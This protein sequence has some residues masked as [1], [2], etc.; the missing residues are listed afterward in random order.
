MARLIENMLALDPEMH[1]VLHLRKRVKELFSW[2][3]QGA[4]TTIQARYPGR[5]SVCE[6]QFPP[7]RVLRWIW[8]SS[9]FLPLDRT[10]GGI[11]IYHS[12]NFITPPLRKARGVVTI[13]DLIMLFPEFGVP[14]FP[15]EE[16]RRYIERADAILAISEHTKRDII[17][18]FNVPEDKVRVTLLAADERFRCIADPEGIR[19][20]L[21]RFGIEGD[22]VLYTGPMELRK[23]VPAIVRAFATLKVEKR[24]PHRL[25]L[26]G[27]KGGGCYDEVLEI[28]RTLGLENDVI[29]TGFV[30]DEDMPYLYNGA[31]LFAFPSLYEG[32]GL[33]PLE[34]MACGCPVVTSNTSSLPEVVGDAG[35]MVDPHRPEELA[36]AMGKILGDSAL[37]AELREKGLRRAAE[38]SWRRCAEE[39]LAVYRFVLGK[40]IRR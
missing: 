18:F 5:I 27:N 19:S 39:T 17:H 11:D 13:Y 10:L 3:Y 34:A 2:H 6:R 21:G 22:Y 40:G 14:L 30:P 35:L 15:R 31:A 26:A 20:V 36:D 37:R 12:T 4:G 1:I 25:V 29:F 33:P 23:N 24:V 32:F 16:L 9:D 28:V 8:R 7:I 38:F